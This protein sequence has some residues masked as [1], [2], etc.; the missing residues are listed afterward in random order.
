MRRFLPLLLLVVAGCRIPDPAPV[1]IDE[2]VQFGFSRYA[3]DEDDLNDRT[4]ADAAEN[5]TLWWAENMEDGELFTASDETELRAEDL[6]TLD[7]PSSAAESEALLGVMVGRVTDCTLEDIDRLYFIDDQRSLFPDN[8]VGYDR[9]RTSDF[10]CFLEAEGCEEI[11][12]DSDVVQETNVIGT[13]VTREFTIGSGLRRVAAVPSEGT[14]DIV[15]ARFSRT[16]MLDPA[17]MTPTIA[18]SDFR[19]NYQLEIMTPFEGG[20]IHFYGMWTDLRSDLDTSA[21]IFVNGYVDGLAETLDALE[22]H[23]Q[24]D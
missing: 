8:Y 7:P 18:N 4:L 24:A 13:I 20:I 6:D 16:W 10:D 19:Q 5:L 12:W 9:T 15:N 23:C 14:T 2:I 1:E 17:V 11:T 21:S 22:A 3:A